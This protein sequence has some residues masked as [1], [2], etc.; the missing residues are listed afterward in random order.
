MTVTPASRALRDLR[1]S[2]RGNALLRSIR[3]A[4]RDFSVRELRTVAR[5]RSMSSPRPK[6]N[7]NTRPP[8]LASLL[9]GLYCPTIGLSVNG[10]APDRAA[11][12][13]KAPCSSRCPADGLAPHLDRHR[14]EDPAAQPAARRSDC[15]PRRSWRTVRRAPL[16]GARSAA[17]PRVRRARRPRGRQ[18]EVCKCHPTRSRRRPRRAS[19]VRSALDDVTFIELWEA[20]RAVAPRTAALAADHGDP[21]QVAHLEA[22]VAAVETARSADAAVVRSWSFSASSPN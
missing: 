18:Q 8:A 14:A 17:P 22:I 6:S 12:V 15:R 20:M 1:H 21:A 13:Y 2:S 7:R 19:G 11:P 16:D 5:S 3:R 10:A 4:R 9:T